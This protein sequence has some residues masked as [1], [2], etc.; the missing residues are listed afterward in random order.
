MKKTIKSLHSTVATVTLLLIAGCASSSESRQPANPQ[1][2]A[3]S[4]FTKFGRNKIH[5]VIAGK[6]K[7]AIVLVH[8]WSGN[9]SFWRE[10]IPARI[11]PYIARP[12]AIARLL[13]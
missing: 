9:L 11:S 12:P 5:Y 7:H 10:Q 6:G 3:R 8:C 2:D 1:A 4:H 13:P